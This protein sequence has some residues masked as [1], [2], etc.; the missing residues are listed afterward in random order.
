MR[1]LKAYR[2]ISELGLCKLL[3]R[4]ADRISRTRQK[5]IKKPENLYRSFQRH[6]RLYRYYLVALGKRSTIVTARATRKAEKLDFLAL[7]IL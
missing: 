5:K 3:A 2:S 7:Y 4:S 6:L 1:A